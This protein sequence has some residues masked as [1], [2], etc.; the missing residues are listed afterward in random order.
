MNR[1]Q[2]FCIC[3]QE[4]MLENVK[5]NLG[6]EYEFYATIPMQRKAVVAIKNK[7]HKK[8]KHKNNPPVSRSGSLHDS[9]KKKDNMLNISTPT[10]QVT[11]EHM[12]D[13]EQLPAPMVVLGDFNAHNTLY[14]SKK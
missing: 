2:P 9:E 11:E 8:T 6:R 3:L 7:Q 14:G 4:V 13:L 5:Y 1:F 10:D 12:R